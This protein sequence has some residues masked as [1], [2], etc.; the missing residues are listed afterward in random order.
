MARAKLI[1]PVVFNEADAKIIE[2]GKK[3]DERGR[4][5]PRHLVSRSKLLRESALKEATRRIA[6]AKE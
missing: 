6:L 4:R 1:Y 2:Q 3:L 5:I